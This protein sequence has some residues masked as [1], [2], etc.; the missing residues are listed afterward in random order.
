M[1][2]TPLIGQN[3]PGELNDFTASVCSPLPEHSKFQGN[4]PTKDPKKFRARPSSKRIY[5]HNIGT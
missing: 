4:I 3:S 1:V 5:Q 2:A